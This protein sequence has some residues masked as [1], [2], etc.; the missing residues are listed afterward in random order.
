FSIVSYDLYKH[1]RDNTQGFAELAA[2][3]AGDGSLF[4]VRRASGQEA[5]QS[6]AGKFVS[7]NYFAMFG[8]KAIAGRA[9]SGK[10]DRPEAPPVAV[11]SYRLWQEKYASDPSV[12]GGVFNLNDK[13][14]TV[15]GITPPGFFGDTLSNSAPDFFLPLATEPLVQGVSSLLHVPDAHWLDL[16]GRIEPGAKPASIE[17]RMRIELK[18]WLRS[19]WGEMDA[20]TRTNLPRQTLYLSAG[21]AGITSMRE[22][23]EHWLNVLM[24][25]SGFVLLIVC[26]NVANLMLVR[27][28]ERRQ[29]TSLSIALGARASRLVRQALTESILLSFLGGAAGLAIAFAGTRL[30][31]HFA[32]SIPEG[33][34]SVPIDPSPSIPVLLF[35][36][37]IS[38][39][40]GVVFGIAPAWMTSRVD[41][42]EALRGVNRATSRSGSLPRKAL[43]VLQAALSLVLLSASGLLTVA[44]R[45]P[46]TQNFGFEQ[47]RR[48]IVNIDPQLAGYRTEQ[49]TPLYRRI[50]DSFASVSGVS[51]IA[52]CS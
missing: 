11:M 21:G 42:I 50:H 37:T 51:S 40:T 8:V 31:L 19:H 13:P 20:N 38:L 49:L 48:T 7:G 14:F 26:A 28:I 1:F 43:V 9:L 4:A 25:V 3:Q 41:P 12:I 16:I 23:Y 46:E 29:Q 45:N 34:A 17:A 22:Q 39:I 35:A 44:L 52:M 24:M 15:V 10:D 30:I 33:F 18:Q 47:D 5:A 36:F 6:P 2:F 32:F 27:G